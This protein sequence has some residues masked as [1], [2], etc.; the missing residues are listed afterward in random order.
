MDKK[1][2]ALRGFA[3][4]YK[5]IGLIVGIFG[6]LFGLLS[7]SSS[8]GAGG[9]WVTAVIGSVIVGSA[10][11]AFSELLELLIDIEANTRTTAEYFQQRGQSSKRTGV[12]SIARNKQ[13]D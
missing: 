13:P 7:I 1:Y 12:R 9:S 4:F 2:K 11:V 10:F 6:T 5:I 8:F 3:T